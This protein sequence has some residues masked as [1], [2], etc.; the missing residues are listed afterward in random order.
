VDSAPSYFELIVACREGEH[1]IS[2]WLY[3]ELDEL[4]KNLWLQAHRAQLAMVTRRTQILSIL[5]KEVA[6][7]TETPPAGRFVFHRIDAIAQGAEPVKTDSDRRVWFLRNP[8]VSNR[9]E[10]KEGQGKR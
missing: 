8:A 5:P 2:Y 1:Q 10:S 9:D 4:E 7:D 6:I 3:V